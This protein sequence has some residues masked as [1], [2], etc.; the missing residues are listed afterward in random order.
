MERWLIVLLLVSCKG[1]SPPDPASPT[2]GTAQSPSTATPEGAAGGSEPREAAQV[3]PGPEA[4]VSEAELTPLQAALN[5]FVTESQARRCPVPPLRGEARPGRADAAIEAILR[6]S[7]PEL[8]ACAEAAE[9]HRDAL[10]K[11]AD[12]EPD[13]E[14]LEVVEACDALDDAVHAAAAHED[15][16]SPYLAGRRGLPKI[17]RA[18]ALGRAVAAR[19]QTH[20]RAGRQEEALSL[21]LDWL[22]VTQHLSRGP[23]APLLAAMAGNAA[24]DTMIQ[25]VVAP[26]LG[27]GASATLAERAERELALLLDGE[28]RFA[29]LLAYERYALPLQTVL[30]GLRGRGWEPPGG[31]DEGGR[32]MEGGTL[33]AEFPGVGEREALMLAWIAMDRNGER[34]TAACPP[35]ATLTECRTGLARLQDATLAKQPKGLGSLLAVAAAE[36]QRAAVRDQILTILESIAQPSFARYVDRLALRR[37]QLAAARVHAAV[38]VSRARTGTCPTVAELEAPHWA[39]RLQVPGVAEAMTVEA[40]DVG[41]V[42]TPPAEIVDGARRYVVTCAGR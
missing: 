17:L 39:E 10:A 12:G 27:P 21:A 4:L 14:V 20:A 33:G 8:V 5:A 18:L 19:A 35:E 26:L 38:A 29:D 24:V 40:S 32:P 30:P 11:Q 1:S 6:P 28:P 9:R 3:T 36:D 2:R 41:I 31:F 37:F 16:C 34:M 23:G 13:P 42:L 25:G 15:A 7:T 22:R